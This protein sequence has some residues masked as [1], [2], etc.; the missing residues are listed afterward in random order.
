MAVLRPELG[1]GT[2][3]CGDSGEIR[4]AQ[5]VHAMREDEA[6]MKARFAWL[7]VARRWQRRA[8]ELRGGGGKN[9]EEE[10]GSL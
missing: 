1:T 2:G 6:N 5:V 4:L 9:R 10:K 8:A 3:G 7:E